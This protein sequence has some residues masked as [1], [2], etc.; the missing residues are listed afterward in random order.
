MKANIILEILSYVYSKFLR[1]LV[2]DAINNPDK[3][4]D[5]TV[6][7]LLDRLFGYDGN[8]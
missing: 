6:L 5:D 4:W 1:E 3:T 7:E 2:K 8:S